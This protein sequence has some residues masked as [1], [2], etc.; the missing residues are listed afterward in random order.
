MEEAIAY[1]MY[2]SIVIYPR[3]L[4][5]CDTCSDFR[6]CF[7]LIVFCVL[8]TKIHQAVGRSG[9]VSLGFAD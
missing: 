9:E 7:L 4:W 6:Q 1:I 5:L 2:N 3:C 8:D